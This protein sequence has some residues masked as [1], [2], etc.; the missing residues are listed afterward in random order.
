MK[1]HQDAFGH[2]VYDYLKGTKGKGD[3]EVIE[4]DD[5]F[6]DV[7]AGPGGYFSEYKD[8]P[9][10]LKKAMRYAKGRVIDIGCGA[11]RHSLYLQEKGLD[12]LG[13]DISPLAIKVCK[14]R[15]L[16]KAKVVSITQISSKLG[17]FDTI[18]MLG[19]NFGLFGSF[20]RAKWLLK[21]LRS[22]T[23][24][25]ARIIAQSHDPY[26]TD[27]PDHLKYHEFNRKRGRMGGQIRL[28]VRYR[29]YVTPWFDYL[30]VSKDEMGRILDGTGWK[31]KDFIDSE[32]SGY[33]AIIEKEGST[34]PH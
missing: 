6:I 21:R 7:S 1:D 4:R 20:K 24:D 22:L 13:I 33:L 23:N 9:P 32:S 17:K 15:G 27:D 18:L 10:Q 14:L 8:W 31:V 19:N 25:R 30:F 5:G 11:G 3:S 26:Q 12:V 16:K 28:R 34:T 2:Q 29:K